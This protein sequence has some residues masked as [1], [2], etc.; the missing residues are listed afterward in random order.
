M[1]EKK[2]KLNDPE[3]SIDNN[4][5]LPPDSPTEIARSKIRDSLGATTIDGSL[6][7]TIETVHTK[8]TLE[9]QKTTHIKPPML[10]LDQLL[11]K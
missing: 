1:I 5:L 10:Q 7:N 3:K 2:I 6:E 11:E 4:G 8:N 9:S